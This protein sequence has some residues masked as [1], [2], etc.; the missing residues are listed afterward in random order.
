MSMGQKKAAKTRPLSERIFAGA[1]MLIGFAFVALIILHLRP[2][3][4]PARWVIRHPLAITRQP[5]EG[6]A[7]V[8]QGE[9]SVNTAN[10]DELTCLPGVG[11][12]LAEA[13]VYERQKNGLF[14]YPEDL[15]NVR[16][17][18]EKTLEKILPYVNF[19]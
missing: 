17:I 9:I 4:L 13:I 16:G 1:G 18:G 15:L 5:A 14:Y 2:Q 7:A 8:V 6:S 19:Q 3:N 10:A 11:P 12:S